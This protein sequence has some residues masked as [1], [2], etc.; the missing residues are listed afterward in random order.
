MHLEDRRALNVD[1]VLDLSHRRHS[2][3]EMIGIPDFHD[4]FTFGAIVHPGSN[5]GLQNVYIMIAERPLPGRISAKNTY[6]TCLCMYSDD[7]K[8]PFNMLHTA[9]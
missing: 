1:D 7:Y 8:G 4:E 9:A 2:P 5:I 6:C 3:L